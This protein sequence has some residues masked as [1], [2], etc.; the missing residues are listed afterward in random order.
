[1]AVMTERDAN[2][3]VWLEDRCEFSPGYPAILST[4]Q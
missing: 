2:L 4:S 1:M 3:L